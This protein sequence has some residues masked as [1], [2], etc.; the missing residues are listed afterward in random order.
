[1]VAPHGDNRY[2]NRCGLNESLSRDKENG[3]WNDEKEREIREFHARFGPHD[4]AWK[5]GDA[6]MD[7]LCV[8]CSAY[9]IRVFFLRAGGATGRPVPGRILRELDT[10]GESTLSPEREG[11]DGQ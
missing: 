8:T 6:T 4:V 1:M 5:R 11:G 2:C 10:K 9:L 3:N 7:L